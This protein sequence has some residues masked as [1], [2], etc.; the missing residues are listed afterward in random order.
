MT[1]N[2]TITDSVKKSLLNDEKVVIIYGARQTG[3]TTIANNILNSISG[4]I[5][6]VNA[7]K[8][9]YI[10]LLS[11]RDYSRMQ[12]LIEGYDVLFIDEAQRIPDLGINLKII[13]DNNPQLKILVTGSSSF[14]IANTV[15]EPLTGRTSTYKLHPISLHELK[16]KN[17]VFELQNRLEEFMTYGLYPTLLK[18]KNAN[19]KEK[20]IIELSNSYLYK[21]I[22]ELSNI[23]NSSQIN[24]LLKL[25]AF[26]IGSE[27]SINELAQNLGM[28]QE[29]VN[30][31]IDLLEKS[32]IVFRLSGFSKNLRKEITKR[33]KIMFWDLGVRNCIINN[34]A[35]LDM[36]NDLGAMWENFIIA[37]RIKYLSNIN[38]NVSSYFWRTYTGAEVD[39]IEEKNGILT[40]FEIKYKKA[41]KKAP[42]TWI[43][44]YGNNFHC[45]THYNFWEYIMK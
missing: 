12:L 27:V 23:R 16:D 25:L 30:N 31:Y 6:R 38:M 13:H 18:Y 20:Y 33:D 11:S 42:Q 21:D 2:R 44:N 35:P 40:A 28:S 15:N 32:F 9:K 3:K 4:K 14:D 29:T 5:L 36:R 7:D 45:I 34:F 8:E 19:D 43:D 10:E 17:S 1:I 39:Y 24:K 22:L 37:E 41:R 26:Q